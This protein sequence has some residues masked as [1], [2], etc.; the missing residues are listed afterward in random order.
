[1]LRWFV[2]LLAS[3]GCTTDPERPAPLDPLPLP[4]GANTS[5]FVDD[6]A[7]AQCHLVPDGATPL[8]DAAGHNVSPVLLWRSSMM[9]LAARDPYYLAVFAEER[10]RAPARTAEIDALCSRCHAP[11]GSEELAVNGQHLSFDQL[12]A[13]TD[14]AA[15]LGRGGVTCTLCHQIA[16]SN[17]GDEGSFSGG[18]RVG[19]QRQL[20][21]RYLNPLTEPMQLIVNFTPTSGAQIAESSLCG[22]CHT[23]IVPGPAGE[24]VEQATFLEWR[25]SKYPALGRTCQACHVPTVDEAGAPITV[26]AISR[27]PAT[28]GARTPFGRH[29]FVGGNSYVLRLLA[30]ALDWSGAGVSADELLASAS[31]DDAHLGEAARVELVAHDAS[32]FSLRVTNLTGH[33]LPT[34]YPSRRI[35]LHVRVEVGG[36]VVFETGGVD[37]RGAIVD[38]VGHV[39]AAQP[40]RDSITAEDEVQIWESKLIDLGGASTHRALDARR[41]GKDDRILPAGF[42]P[43]GSDRTRT[44][45]AGPEFDPNF[46]P[47]SDDVVYQPS[48]GVPAGARLHVE[49]VYEAVAPEIVDAIETG[50]TP[51]GSRFVDLSRARPIAPVVLATLDVNL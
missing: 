30:D 38:R 51:A 26:L 44:Q 50:A 11:A 31:R 15:N 48:G 29:T 3:A 25:S 12:T 7:C 19:Y 4:A 23:V 47:G 14:P 24:V 16:A 27:T 10:T 41:Y 17:L 6:G 13:S 5:R 8:H 1:M 28:L 36:E 9:A 34:G 22:A 42:A 40:H 37:T 33:K 21:G 2:V 35:W 20:F 18:F 49:L 43:T 45:P 32:G 46:L 39:L